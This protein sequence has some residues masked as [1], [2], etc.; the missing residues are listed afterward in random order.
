MTRYI[1][2]V[3]MEL[4]ASVVL[5]LSQRGA[6]QDIPHV[7]KGLPI[8]E[9]VRDHPKLMFADNSIIS[10][11]EPHSPIGYWIFPDFSL[12]RLLGLVRQMSEV[13]K[14][15]EPT[16]LPSRKNC[17]RLWTLARNHN[18]RPHS[19]KWRYPFSESV[20]GS[21]GYFWASTPPTHTHKKRW[22]VL[23]NWMSSFES[24]LMIT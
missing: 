14:S 3:F 15:P 11:F 9:L 5:Q 23:T 4:G 24:T 17:L 10:M 12:W 13:P 19:R 22:Y 21:K 16:P 6:S 2:C 8:R 20:N 18:M 1:L 7:G